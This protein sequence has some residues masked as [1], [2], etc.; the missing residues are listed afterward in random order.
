VDVLYTIAAA[1]F[2]FISSGP[3]L[4]ACALYLLVA[5]WPVI[6]LHELGHAMVAVRRLGGDVE[7]T[8]G[9]AVK[10]AQLRLGQVNASLHALQSPL[11]TAGS[12]TFDASRARAEDVLRV[13]L[14]GPAVS[15]LNFV[16]LVGAYS[17][18]PDDGVLHDLLWAGTLASLYGVLN[19][20]PFRLQE[21]GQSSP[22]PSDG[23]LARDA[24]RVMR[25]LR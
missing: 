13:A 12:V 5:D 18:A 16:G 1:L 9:N 15:A 10:L 24:L 25:E 8:V 22:Q 11:G 17:I 19:V 2:D 6:L 14:A 23:W 21:L 20:I 4:L 3:G 7:V